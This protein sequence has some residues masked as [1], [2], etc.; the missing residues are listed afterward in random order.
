M[1]E[2]GLIKDANTGK[3]IYP[4]TDISC[5]INKVVI[6]EGEELTPEVGKYYRFDEPVNTLHITLPAIEQTDEV[7][8]IIVYLTVGNTPSIT[9]T[10]EDDTPIEYFSGYN[11]ELMTTYELNFM[12][13]GSKWILGYGAIC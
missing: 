7:K 13:N 2:K 9:I 11:I 5:I 12:F 3:I 4:I 6:A 10:S 8:S 1:A